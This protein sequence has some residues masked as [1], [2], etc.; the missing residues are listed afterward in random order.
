M[1]AALS[2]S[3]VFHILLSLAGIVLIGSIVAAF[4]DGVVNDDEFRAGVLAVGLLA[5]A[6]IAIWLL[7]HFNIVA[8]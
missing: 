8:W 7:F 6:G 2:I 1:I 4:I 3:S 5:V